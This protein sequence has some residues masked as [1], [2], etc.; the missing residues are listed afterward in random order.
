MVLFFFEQ[1]K[2]KDS[3]LYWIFNIELFKISLWELS[4]INREKKIVFGIGPQIKQ[5]MNTANV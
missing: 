4:V 1:K 5:K 3:C 2:I